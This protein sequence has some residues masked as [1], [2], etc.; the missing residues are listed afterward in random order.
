MMDVFVGLNPVLGVLE[1]SRENHILIRILMV[2]EL[3]MQEE[4]TSF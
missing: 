4:A 3:V 1:S 2:I